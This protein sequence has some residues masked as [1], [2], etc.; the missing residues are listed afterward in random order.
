MPTDLSKLS[1]EQLQAIISQKQQAT[2]TQGFQDKPPEGLMENLIEAGAT[3]MQDLGNL[4]YSA[5]HPVETYQNIKENTVNEA[6]KA[7][8]AFKKGDYLDAIDTAGRAIPIAGPIAGDILDSFTSGHYGRAATGVGELLTPELGPRVLK[9]L[10]SGMEDARA[11]KVTPSGRMAGRIGGYGLGEMIHHP[12]LG[13]AV[14]GEIIPRIPDFI[15]G[16]GRGAFNIGSDTAKLPVEAPL[17]SEAPVKEG[18]K[19][20]LGELKSAVK[21]GAI[22]MDEFAALTAKLG[23]SPEN[24][25]ILSKTLQ[26]QT[27]SPLKVEYESKVPS[28]ASMSQAQLEKAV[29]SGNATL[30]DYSSYLDRKRVIPVDKDVL[31]KEMKKKLDEAESEEESELGLGTVNPPGGNHITYDQ[32]QDINT[33]KNLPEGTKR[34]MPNG[35]VQILQRTP[36]DQIDPD[37][38]ESGGN[39]YDLAKVEE[40]EKKGSWIPPEL[41]PGENGRFIAQEGHHRLAAAERLGDSAPLTWVPEESKVMTQR[42][43]DRP[44]VEWQSKPTEHEIKQFQ[45]TDREAKENRLAQHL[46]ESKHNPAEVPTVSIPDP[47]YLKQLGK[48]AGLK[49]EPS[50]Q[51]YTNA[52]KKSKIIGL[53]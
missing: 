10:K 32:S 3:G 7:T 19:L 27:V 44:I 21:N 35:K 30:G 49:Y 24:I 47:K 42:Q 11:A 39:K 48:D 17:K 9:G 13:A 51:T 26:P 5:V 2:G 38:N 4:A 14:G 40:Y 43:V 18:P 37:F 36:L 1:D 6:G 12:Y 20:S 29:L 28:M 8:K 25:D 46:V 15:S 41:K 52:L 53:K 22:S 23:H 33:S 34:T 16:F 50:L 31:M 45:S